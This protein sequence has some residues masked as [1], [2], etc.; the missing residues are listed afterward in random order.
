MGRTTQE[1]QWPSGVLNEEV[2]AKDM[3]RGTLPKAIALSVA[4]IG[5]GI[6]AWPALMASTDM[7]LRTIALLVG[8]GIL[9]V[10]AYRQWCGVLTK[11]DYRVEEDRIVGKQMQTV[12]ED[13]DAEATGMATRV[14]TLELEK[15][16]SYRIVADHIHEG[17]R[18]YELY[19]MLEEGERLYLVYAKKSNQL[20][21]IYRQKFWTME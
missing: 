21:R 1:P 6:A 16:G 9:V 17:Y 3:K 19:H 5:L 4:A 10:L 2:V 18:E 12:Y 8:T 14:P 15:H 20:L 7:N 11:P 13:R